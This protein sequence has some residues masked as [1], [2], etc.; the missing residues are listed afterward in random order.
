M[1]PEEAILDVVAEYLEGFTTDVLPYNAVET[2]DTVNAIIGYRRP[3]GPIRPTH[4]LRFANSIHCIF[5]VGQNTELFK[6]MVDFL[7]WGVYADI[8]EKLEKVEQSAPNPEEVPARHWLDCPIARQKI[9]G[10]FTG[11]K[12]RL[13]PEDKA[14]TVSPESS[15]ECGLSQEECK[16]SH[17]KA[18]EFEQMLKRKLNGWSLTRGGLTSP[19]GP[20]A[21]DP[22][23]HRIFAPRS[24]HR[25]CT[26]R[27]PVNP[28]TLKA[29]LDSQ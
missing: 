8:A 23:G 22:A 25:C 13:I 6:A 15:P 14:P 21:K 19:S 24:L 9:K 7:Y 11:C 12:T 27:K 29:K 26:A 20:S 17:W 2:L 10:A 1:N 5:S 18:T 16:T 4:Q 28:S 3:R